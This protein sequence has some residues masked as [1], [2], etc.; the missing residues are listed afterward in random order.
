MHGIGRSIQVFGA[1]GGADIYEGQYDCNDLDGFGVSFNIHY[2]GNI[3]S[4]IGFWKDG[5]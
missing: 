2:D 3:T 1:N 4:Y 5:L